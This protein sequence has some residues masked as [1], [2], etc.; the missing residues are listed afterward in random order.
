M[1]SFQYYEFH[2][3]DRPLNEEEQAHISSLSS[4]VQLTPRQAIFTYAYG[5][6]RG[7]PLELLARSFDM[8]FYQ[9]NWGT[10]Q[11]AFRFP[12][13]TIDPQQ[14]EPY[15]IGMSIE[16]L[17]KGEY[18]ILNISIT[19]EDMM[20]WIE[21]DGKGGGLLPLRDAIIQ[22]DLRLLYIAWLK[23]AQ[24]D[25]ALDLDNEGYPLSDEDADADLANPPE[26]PVPPGLQSLT[27]SLQ[28]G[29]A[30]FGI[31][32]DLVAAAA[33]ASASATAQADQF[34][35]WVPLL[36]EAER[37]AFLVRIAQDDSAARPELIRRLREVGGVATGS[38][39]S[40][41]PRRT[42][43]EL[44]DRA[45]DHARQ[46]Q[47][48]EQQAAAQARQRELDALAPR[49]DAIWEEVIALIEQKNAAGYDR[50]TKLLVD[51]RDL[52][53][54]QRQQATFE[55]RLDK[56]VSTYANRSA[57]LRRLRKVGLA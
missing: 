39:A 51:L 14:I 5:D 54:R 35:R 23:A 1:S 30:V 38:S 40:A 37:N 42:L 49:A 9:A 11:L 48:R 13:S 4:R 16:L 28:H 8:L 46:R 50:A 45:S 2:A 57:L 19:D 29:M 21:P 27:A 7:D 3:V 43:R 18:T 15:C 52:A 36:P 17:P 20:D 25:E 53:A 34:A 10:T 47:A 22:G 56:I 55:A 33:E 6:F 12:S 44:L 24:H 26:P 32:S 31:D 41:T